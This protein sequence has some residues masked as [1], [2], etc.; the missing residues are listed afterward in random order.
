MPSA[1]GTMKRAP[2]G[3]RATAAKPGQPMPPPHSAATRPSSTM[4]GP[5]P[6]AIEVD[7][8]EVA[9][10]IEPEP[11]EDVAREDDEAGAA[12]AERHRPA[13]EIGDGAVLGVAARDEHAGRRVHR[14][15]DAEIGGRAT[16][17]RESLVRHLALHER[18]VEAA[19]LEEGHVLRAALGVLRLHREGRIRLRYRLREGL[20]VDGEAAA[21]GR[22]AEGHRVHGAF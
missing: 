14:G 13:G 5:S 10:L 19:R 9:R 1:S 2:A 7:G 3:P 4:A 6:A 12:R 15:E 18:Q 21:G 17:A 8:M 11:I 16:D 20:A 22:G